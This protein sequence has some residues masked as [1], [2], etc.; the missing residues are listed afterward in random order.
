MSSP[1]GVQ[2]VPIRFVPTRAAPNLPDRS[3]HREGKVNWWSLLLLT[4]M[5]LFPMGSDLCIAPCIWGLL[6]AAHHIDFQPTNRVFW[7][8]ALWSF[9]QT[10]E[11][12]AGCVLNDIFDRDVDGLVERSS[13]RPLVTGAVPLRQ[14]VYLALFLHGIILGILGFCGIPTLCAGLV[15]IVFFGWPYPLMKRWTNW[16]Q[17]WLGLTF[18]WGI[19]KG[20]LSLDADHYDTCVI[21]MLWC[22]N[23]C[24]T[25][26]Y[27]TI[28]ACQ[29]RKDDVRAGVKS[30]AVLFGE[31]VRTVLSLFATVFV[32][33][34]F[35]AGVANEHGLWYFVVS[36]GGASCHLIWQLYTINFENRDDCKRK[37]KSNGT[38]G[39]IVSLGLL[40]D[41]LL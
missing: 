35:L 18:G 29:D 16:P 40:C 36:V 22:G 8:L 27:D 39:L 32:A 38:L 7:M 28:Y 41:Y 3:D 11:H 6:M 25:I 12:S 13:G 26:V 20:W 31:R 4:R 17:A 5:H 14:A 21:A 23:T 33:C 10:V 37:F 34:L 24:W 19:M 30:T 1:S 2:K 15:G 9:E